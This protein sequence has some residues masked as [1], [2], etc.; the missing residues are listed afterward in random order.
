MEFRKL[1]HRAYNPTEY[2]EHLLS[3]VSHIA[4]LFER[5][6]D[7][8]DKLQEAYY[9]EPPKYVLPPSLETSKDISQMFT[10]VESIIAN[11]ELFLKEGFLGDI[12]NTDTMTAASLVKEVETTINETKDTLDYHLHFVRPFADFR[13][14]L[15]KTVRKLHVLLAKLTNSL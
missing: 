11:L 10:V 3:A 9:K 5:L 2:C 1:E 12:E 7:S 6:D 15:N 14:V 13:A 4:Q 8:N